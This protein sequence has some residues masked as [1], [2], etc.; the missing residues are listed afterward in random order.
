MSATRT[1]EVLVPA[2][3]MDPLRPS[4]GNTY[5]RRL[6]E[7]LVRAGWSVRVREV[8][9]DWPW[10]DRASR[11]ALSA[12][13]GAAGD[14]S[15]VVVD[16]LVASAC[17]EAVVP[18][19]RRLR[20]V[21][22]V[23]LPLGVSAGVADR[24]RE[25]AVVR[26]SAAVVTTSD[27]TRRWLLAAYGLDPARVHVAHPGVDSARAAGAGAAG[28]HLLCVGAV[29]P[30]KGHDLLVEALA[31]VAD[32]AWR[33][34]CVGPL[35]RCPDFVTALRRAIHVAGLDDRV[36][37]VGPRAG[38]DLDATYAEADVLV[39][40]SRTESYGMVVTEAL[41]RGLPVLGSD[42]GGVAEALGV[43]PDGSRPGVLV[44]PGD[45]AALS[46]AVRRWLD[47][48]ALRGR[49]REAAGL[50]RTGLAGWGETAG[51]VAR[52]LEGV[53]A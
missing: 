24:R 41:A 13:L 25:A 53:A 11:A 37:L 46:V 7:E 20:T 26:A 45:V 18:A 44:P 5:D 48:A 9:G 19:A 36:R 21:V 6:C 22:L 50:R 2:G 47:D 32:R 31:G 28:A 30:G 10:A 4:G 1:V 17:P 49:L 3:I 29:T 38:G 43:A 52:V 40:P 51:R 16:G 42:V 15:V 27:W 14:G 35:D 34:V 39:L 8:G 23:H 33:C 12:A